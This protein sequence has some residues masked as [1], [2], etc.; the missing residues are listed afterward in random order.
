MD[1]LERLVFASFLSHKALKYP[2]TYQNMEIVN[3]SKDECMPAFS[4][5]LGLAPHSQRLANLMRSMA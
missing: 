5:S 4:L 3:K 1:S 2:S